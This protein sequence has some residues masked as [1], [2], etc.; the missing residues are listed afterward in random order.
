MG[1]SLVIGPSGF[2][3]SHVTRQLVAAGH[4]VR[5]LARRTS[6]LRG[7]EGLAVE[8][9][10]GDIFDDAALRSAMAGCDVVFYCVVDT[11]AWLRDPAPLFRTNV[12]GLRHVLDVAADAGLRRFVFTSSLATIGIRDDG[13]PATE[14]DACNWVERG[15]PYV[16]SRIAA[17]ELVL[18]YCRERS[19]PGI[20]LCVANTYGA[21]D[22]GATPHGKLV[23]AAARGQALVYFDKFAAEAV[24]I[25]DA[26]AALCLAADNGRV[27]ERYIISERF[28]SNREMFDVAADATGARRP[29]VKIPLWL[30][31]A[32]GVIGDLVGKLFRRDVLLTSVSVRLSYVTTPMDHSKAERELGWH[33]RPVQ[34]SIRDAALF[35]RARRRH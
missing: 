1:T 13:S 3:G 15:G 17:E 11:R 12:E 22:W 28:I 35:Y 25:E 32:S 24:G 14:D 30:A 20:V 29:M 31:R 10:Y 2:L 26:A 4:D 33:P 6:N 9:H 18:R 19:L 16:E 23:D 8:R 21:D 5:V 7:I 27:G 34:D